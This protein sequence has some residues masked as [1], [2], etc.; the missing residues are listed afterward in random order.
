M[1]KEWNKM[2]GNKG[3]MK[4]HLKYWLSGA[5]VAVAVLT[6][7]LDIHAAT[8]VEFLTPSGATVNSLSVNAEADFLLNNGSI[9]ITLINQ[10][11][12]PTSVAQL[13]S[14]ISF[15]VTGA[16]GSGL[17][18]TINS[19]L[20]TTISSDGSYTAGTPDLL[21]R[22]EATETG[23]NIGL[24]T[25]SGGNPDHLIIGPDSLGNLIPSLG[26]LYKSANASIIGDN[27]NILGSALFLINIPGVTTDSKIS[28]VI[29]KFNTTGDSVSGTTV[30]PASVP[31]GGCTLALLGLASIG[32][33]TMSRRL[34]K[35]A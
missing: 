23:Q 1:V 19:G 18:P 28:N 26:G 21:T 24:T 29:F 20:A 31:D 13:L 11:G 7:S 9:A 16:S 15:D 17:L 12:N 5:T 35:S 33:A 10:Q 34:K 22:W 4:T 2:V 6:T 32:L 25:L 3:P 8:V 14:G 30:E 27:P